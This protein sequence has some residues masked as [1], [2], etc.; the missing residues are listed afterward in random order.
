MRI[1]GACKVSK[2]GVI[3]NN[4]SKTELLA[5][6]DDWKKELYSSLKIDYPKFH[7]MDALAKM[8]F[9]S[10]Q[11][12]EQV[13]E[14]DRFQDDEIAMLF[15]N[16]YSS[17][18]TDQKYLESYTVKGS[19][20]PSLFVY[21]LPNI[22]TGELS[23]FKKWYGENI[24]FIHENFDPEF[25]IDQINFYLSK[26]AKACLCGWVDAANENEECLLFMVDNTTGEITKD[27]LL[28][29]YKQ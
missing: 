19:P 25:F 24:F 22:L 14:T 10:F 12:L 26:G 23:I 13:I 7:K 15:A 6:S 9:L 3:V 20:S 18:D 16:T 8:A 5:S 21:T 4:E 28:N 27:E 2:E 29:Y 1:L 11:Y 17:Y